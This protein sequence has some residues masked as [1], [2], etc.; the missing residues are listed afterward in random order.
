MNEW[1]RRLAQAE[2]KLS[3]LRETAR[4]W[5]EVLRGPERQ[6]L[7]ADIVTMLCHIVTALVDRQE[8]TPLHGQRCVACGGYGPNPCVYCAKPAPLPQVYEGVVCP[9]HAGRAVEMY[10]PPAFA[11]KR[12]RV[13]VL[14]EVR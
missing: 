2:E 3:R 13:E 14:S 10:L 7:Q 4:D 12:V 11:G 6:N 9:A 8:A 5:G 1:K